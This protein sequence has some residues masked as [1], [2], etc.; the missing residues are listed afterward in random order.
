[1]NEQTEKALEDFNDFVV[2]R[3]AEISE[4]IGNLAKIT[5]MIRVPG[6]EDADCVITNDD[7][8]EL[9]ALVERTKAR[10]LAKL[11]EVEGQ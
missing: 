8:T 2:E 7:L 5:L 11:D 10:N 1:M 9:A 3:L 4:R 6:S